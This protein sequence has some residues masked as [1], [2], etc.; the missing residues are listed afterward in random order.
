MKNQTMKAFGSITKTLLKG[1]TVYYPVI[2][3]VLAAITFHYNSSSDIVV[4][5]QFLTTLI[6]LFGM[7]CLLPFGLFTSLI[8]NGVPR[9][10]IFASLIMSGALI[11]LVCAF[12]DRLTEYFFYRYTLVTPLYNLFFYCTKGKITF[13]LA[14]F[15]GGVIFYFFLYTAAYTVA[16]F[17]GLLYRKLSPVMKL[18]AAL[19]LIAINVMLVFLIDFNYISDILN[20]VSG[21]NTSNPFIGISTFFGVTL[22]FGLLTYFLTIRIELNA[23]SEQ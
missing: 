5:Y 15:I 18:S 14:V 2:L 20:S 6:L 8:S 12:A 10:K 1:I 9:R 21:V 19:A 3:C 17:I 13:D 7:G 11:S 22:I 4:G 16:V 23:V